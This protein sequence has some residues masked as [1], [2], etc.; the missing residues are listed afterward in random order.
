MGYQKKLLENGTPNP[1]HIPDTR[2]RQGDRH[3][4]NRNGDRHVHRSQKKDTFIAIDGEGITREDGKHEYVLLMAST[5]EKLVHDDGSELSTVEC[6][7][8]LLDLAKGTSANNL[9]NW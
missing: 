2:K 5:D 8:F 7:D 1:F 4:T 3:A 6:F 9:I